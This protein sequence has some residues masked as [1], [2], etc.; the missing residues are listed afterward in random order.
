MHLGGL[1]MGLTKYKLQQLIE[2]CSGGNENLKYGLDAV[3]GISV[4]KEFIETKAD[5]SG[6]SNF[7]ESS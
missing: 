1:D 3:K 5:L 6:V 7:S 2:V 4:N